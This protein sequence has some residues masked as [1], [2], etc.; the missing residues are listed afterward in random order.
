MGSQP[1]EFDEFAACLRALKERAGLSYE[2]LAGKTGI[3]GSS[4]HRY[5]S[6]SYVPLDYGSAHRFATACGASPEELRRLH[7]LWA[8]ADAARDPGRGTDPDRG[9]DGQTDGRRA[10]RGAGR[11]ADRGAGRAADRG[12]DRGVDQDVAQDGPHGSAPAPALSPALDPAAES[13]PA[14]APAPASAAVPAA[15]S[16]P[17]AAPTVVPAAPRP[18]WHRRRSSALVVIV[19]ALALGATAWGLTAG[20]GSGSSDDGRPLFSAACAGPVAMGQRGVCVREV[21]RLLARAGAELDVDGEFGPQTLRRVTA[22]QVLSRVGATGVVGDETKKALYAGKTSM[23]TWPAEK[24]R[25]RIREVFQEAPDRAVA[26]ADCQ[27]FL[28]PLHVLSNTD[29]TRNWGVFQIS[30]ATLRGL[31]GT[32]RDALDPEWNIQAAHT[33]WSRA[34]NFGDWPNC[35]RAA[36]PAPSAPSTSPAATGPALVRAVHG[37]SATPSPD[38]PVPSTSTA[39]NC[40]QPGQRFKMATHDRVFLVG[41]GSRLYYIPDETVYL[42]LWDDYRGVVTLGGSV[43]ADCGWDEALELADAFMARTSSSLRAYIWDAW[44][45]YRWIE[46]WTVF[47]K[48]GFS[49]AKIQMRSSLSPISDDTRWR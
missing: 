2:A 44:Y 1:V 17:A 40:P 35:D 33:L 26:I 6:G 29:A 43:F 49:P 32:P 8:L 45:G 39:V 3:S 31:G 38:T 42:N 24:V 10:D 28:D 5:C 36:S 11:R 27:S 25:R 22:F 18:P 9:R 12:V 19:L 16:T 47:N 30:D 48:Y 37:R 15:A 41:P 46:D 7:R 20:S 14:A 21:Q 23:D 4:L 13:D 34:R